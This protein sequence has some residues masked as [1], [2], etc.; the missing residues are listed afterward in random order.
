VLTARDG[1]PRS[2]SW[3]RIAPL[4]VG[5]AALAGVVLSRD[6]LGQRTSPVLCLWYLF[7]GG[8]LATFGAFAALGQVLRW[9]AR[10]WQQSASRATGRLASR[11]LWWDS[12]T[13]ATSCAVIVVM[14]VSGMAGAGGVADL[15]AI[16]PTR[17]AGD[18]FD[19]QSIDA[20]ST[21]RALQVPGLRILQVGRGA[22]ALDIASCATL[23]RVVATTA[24]D[25]VDEFRGQC[26][27]GHEF[28]LSGVGVPSATR[29]VL[30]GLQSSEL[31]DVR[32]LPSP[33]GSQVTAARS[34]SII[35]WPGAETDDVD[36]Y[37]AQ[38]LRVAPLTQITDTS[39]DSY[40]PMVAP[41]RRLLLVCTIGGLLVGMCLM[42][43]TSLDT[44]SRTRSQQARLLVLGAGR[45]VAVRAHVLAFGMGAGVALL[46]GLTIGTLVAAVYDM[47]GAMVKDPGVLGWEMA[48][49]AAALTGAGVL[50]SSFAAHRDRGE[51]LTE[52]LRQE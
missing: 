28:R 35:A 4:V 9:C 39:A 37:L 27:P 10:R 19:L 26:R 22:H 18:T 29:I 46:I 2:G 45:G 43:I 31:L 21:A 16:S 36:H 15:A 11:R 33:P 34:P 38:V 12:D 47:A 44:L 40:K 51:P 50:V 52:L 25:L 3:W 13:V 48:A 30:P 8:G 5:V 20:A 41:T 14:A 6:L 24:P 32:V 7:V 49:L 23:A 1:G 42:V 17:A